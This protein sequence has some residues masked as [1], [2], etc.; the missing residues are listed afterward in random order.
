[1]AISEIGLGGQIVKGG[2]RTLRWYPSLGEGFLWFIRQRIGHGHQGEK[3][4]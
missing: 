1:M 4:Q 3:E 2:R